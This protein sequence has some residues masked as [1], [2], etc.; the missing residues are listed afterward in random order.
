MVIRVL[1]EGGVLPSRSGVAPSPFDGVLDGSEVLREALK[2]FFTAVLGLENVS[3]VVTNAAGNRNAAKMFVANP[4]EDYLYTDLDDVPE[5]RVCWFE[6]ME[7][8]GIRIPEDKKQNVFFWIQEMEAWFLKQPQSIEDWANQSGFRIKHPVA[9]NSLIAGKDIEHLQHKPS[10]V[11]VVIFKHDL[12][13]DRKGKDGRPQRL[14]YGK[15]RH[16]PRIIPY[17]EP[18][19]LLQKDAELQAFVESVKRRTE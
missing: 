15:L 11:M 12:Q 14:E 7:K 5:K 13:N 16:A 18:Q 2:K 9:D 10:Y 3:I 6:K 4:M 8:A 1:V 19:K 17:I